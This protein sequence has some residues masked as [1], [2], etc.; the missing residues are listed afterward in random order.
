MEREITL[1]VTH[2]RLMILGS[3]L[4][5]PYGSYSQYRLQPTRRVTGAE[6]LRLVRSGQA[7]ARQ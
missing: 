4:D 3:L 6:P 5:V 7:T 2:D 1:L